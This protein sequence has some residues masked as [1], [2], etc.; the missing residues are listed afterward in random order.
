MGSARTNTADIWAIIVPSDSVTQP[1]YRALYCTVAG[2][3]V[4]TDKQGNDET[5]PLAVG[6]ILP[7]QPVLIKAAGTTATVIGLN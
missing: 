1:E 4:C 6:Q 5:F 2:D 3:V 7:V